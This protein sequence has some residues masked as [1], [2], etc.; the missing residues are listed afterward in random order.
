MCVKRS[1]KI[2]TNSMKIKATLLPK[3]QLI[4]LCLFVCFHKISAMTCDTFDLETIIRMHQSNIMGFQDG[5]Y[6]DFCKGW[7]I[8]QNQSWITSCKI[9]PFFKHRLLLEWLG[10][11]IESHG[12]LVFWGSGNHLVR[13][14]SMV[15]SHCTIAPVYIN[16]THLW[17]VE[18]M[19]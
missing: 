14:F 8:F 4:F 1:I 9:Y 11:I 17:M 18:S 13:W 5:C 7:F 2:C 16:T 15:V 10:A 6:N 12:S 19:E 3:L